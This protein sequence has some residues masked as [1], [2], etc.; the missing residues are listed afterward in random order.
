MVLYMML[1]FVYGAVNED[2]HGLSSCI[3]GVPCFMVL[4]MRLTI[5][6]AAVFEAY[7]G[8]WSCK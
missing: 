3:W 2:S 8:L 4:Y 1:T 7:L 5:V 6:Y